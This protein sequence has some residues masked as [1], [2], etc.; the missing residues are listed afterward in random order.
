[1]ITPYRVLSFSAACFALSLSL[2]FAVLI[3]AQ[4]TDAAAAVDAEKIDA[5]AGID[6]FVDVDAAGADEIPGEEPRAIAAVAAPDEGTDTP[7]P[8]VEVIW[9]NARRREEKIQETPVAVSAFTQEGLDD[10]GAIRIDDIGR[11]VPNLQFDAGGGQGTGARAYIRGIGSVEGPTIWYDPGVGI[12][13][14]GVYLARAQG[15]LL[16][17]VDI[18]RI[19]VLRGPQGTLFGKNTIGGVE[20]WAEITGGNYGRIL[21]KGGV[22]IPLIGGTVLSR[23]S[24]AAGIRDGF[25]TNVFDGS[26]WDDDS[27]YAFNGAF[28][29]LATDSFTVDLA[30]SWSRENER[31]RGAECR[32]IENPDGTQAGDSGTLGLFAF[33]AAVP[34]LPDYLQ[35]CSDAEGLPHRR[36]D[37]DKRGRSDLEQYDVRLT[38]DWD[39]DSFVWGIENWDGLGLKSITAFRHQGPDIASDYDWSELSVLRFETVGRALQEQISTELQLNTSAFDERLNVVVGFYAYWGHAEGPVRWDIL[40][41]FQVPVFKDDTFIGTVSALRSNMSENQRDHSSLAGYTQMA[42]DITD[43]LALTAGARYTS[44]TKRVDRYNQFLAPSLNHLKNELVGEPDYCD[45]GTPGTASCVTFD[46]GDVSVDTSGSETY[47]A[48]TPMVN[49]AFRPRPEWMP[50]II[51]QSLVYYNYSEGFKSGGINTGESIDAYQPEFADS[52]EIGIKSTWWE[53]RLVANVA[54][55]LTDYTDIQ[56]T[57]LDV[58]PDSGLAERIQRNI[59]EAEIRGFEI[60]LFAEPIHHLRFQGSVGYVD[61]DFLEFLDAIQFS[62]TMPPSQCVADIDIDPVA[63]TGSCTIDRSDETAYNTPKITANASLQYGI[64]MGGRWG[65]LVPRIEYYYQDDVRYAVS[66]T[67]FLSSRNHQEAFSLWNFRLTWYPDFRAGNQK[68]LRISAFVNNA[69]DREHFNDGVDLAASL[70]SSGMYFGAPRTY[71]VTVRYD[72]W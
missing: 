35:S 47:G 55:F 18:E 51:E 30:G 15:A 71:G 13:L 46:A 66:S 53:N 19:E 58:N 64:Q 9:V 29:W 48:W 5:A 52:H 37:H 33:N 70:G 36:F 38:L 45:R 24:F 32:L 63:M 61:V 26:S 14:D 11:Y 62:G 16:S 54:F 65:Q 34:G 6:E 22:N 67:A 44:E 28:R 27:L 25:T 23:F 1:V 50:G 31:N 4:E 8:G 3:R 17:T 7:T 59:A 20:A 68:N 42:F 39:M 56:Y 41:G 21:G 60:E 43:Y 40:D 12:Y 69:F 72:F 57:V 10:I 2:C 49:L